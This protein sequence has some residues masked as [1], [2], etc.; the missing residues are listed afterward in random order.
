MF[1]ILTDTVH[2]VLMML[3]MTKEERIEYQQRRAE[4][5]FQRLHHVKQLAK[6]RAAEIAND[7]E[8]RRWLVFPS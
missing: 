3:R 6:K 7:V 8:V 2:I 5:I 4:E 1:V